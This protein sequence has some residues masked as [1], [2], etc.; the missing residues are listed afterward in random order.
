MAMGLNANGLRHILR[1]ASQ[2]ADF[3]SVGTIG[4]Q[5]MHIGFK[6]L[7]GIVQDEFHRDVPTKALE[8]AH[9]TGYADD[10]FQL[11]GAGE[12]ISYDASD[13]EHASVVHDM[14]VDLP[15]SCC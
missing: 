8:A 9:R 11:L 3:S 1:A 4:R 12:V 13:Y 14:N 15:Q 6:S 5:G 2:G 10:L 7:R